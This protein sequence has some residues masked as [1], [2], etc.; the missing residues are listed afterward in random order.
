A[1]L[2][3]DAIS[4]VE[5]HGTGTP[6]GDPIEITGLCKAFGDIKQRCPIGSV[7]SNIGHCEAAAGIAAVTKVLLQLQHGQIAPSLH[8]QALN[9]HI[10]FAATPFVVNQTLCDWQTRIINGKPEPKSAGISSFGAGGSNAHI[11][12]QEWLAVTPQTT[13]HPALIVLSAKDEAHLQ[14]LALNLVNHIAQQQHELALVD[15]AYTLQV[16]RVAMAQRLGFMA[17][18]I[19]QVV[20]VLQAWLDGKANKCRV[21]RIDP[22]P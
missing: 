8:A 17:D 16:G 13:N 18:S 12:I 22:M 11:I 21:N 10:D 2:S 6:L 9:P 20:S 15:L 7:K 19:E 3:A 5:T 14:I 1:G 4:Y